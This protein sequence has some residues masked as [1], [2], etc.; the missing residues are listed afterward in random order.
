[1][2]MRA[3]NIRD[4]KDRLSAHLRRVREGDV[5]LVT[6]RGRVVAEIRQPTV[7]AHVDVALGDRLARLA[8]RGELRL[9]LESGPGT[10]PPSGVQLPAAAVDEALAW[11]RGEE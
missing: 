4:L 6:D 3:V 9:G 5:L 2:A 1:M 7:G 10:V 11:T 8:E